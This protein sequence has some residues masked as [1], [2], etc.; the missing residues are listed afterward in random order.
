M[1]LNQKKQF[2]KAV[3]LGQRIYLNNQ[4]MLTLLSRNLTKSEREL[5]LSKKINHSLDDFTQCITEFE[6]ITGIE[7]N[8]AHTTLKKSFQASDN[9]D[10]TTLYES[11][12]KLYRDDY[13]S[14]IIELTK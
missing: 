12:Q 2:A 1:K 10:L 11:L 8:E 13:L 7:L 3:L 5:N 14:K 9:E 6:E 4:A